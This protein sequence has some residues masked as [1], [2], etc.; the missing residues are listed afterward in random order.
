MEVLSLHFLGGTETTE[1]SA[2]IT[3][4]LVYCCINLTV[5]STF[6][7]KGYIFWDIKPCSPLKFDRLFGGT[8]A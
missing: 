3:D 8:S 1:S 4:I 7:L 2:A 6:I 5:D